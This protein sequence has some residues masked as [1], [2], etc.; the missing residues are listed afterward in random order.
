MDY[1]EAFAPTPDISSIKVILVRGMVRQGHEAGAP[2]LRSEADRPIE[3]GALL[4]DSCR[5]VRYGAMQGKSVCV[6]EDG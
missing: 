5:E 1:F 4:Q 3:V 2:P 6:L